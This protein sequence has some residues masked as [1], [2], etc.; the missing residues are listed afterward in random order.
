MKE[1]HFTRIIF[2]TVLWVGDLYARAYLIHDLRKR[3]KH[4]TCRYDNVE[5]IHFHTRNTNHNT[6]C[7]KNIIDF[8]HSFCYN[9]QIEFISISYEIDGIQKSAYVSKSSFMQNRFKVDFLH[10][11]SIL[12]FNEKQGNKNS[13]LHK[14]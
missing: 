7:L 14:T 6:C 8:L 1:K 10:E 11:N 13:K 5:I 2:S 4:F 3:M 12:R 9:L